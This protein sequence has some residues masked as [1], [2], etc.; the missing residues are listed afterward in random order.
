M[1]KAQNPADEKR[2][3]GAI[4][5][6]LRFF[7]PFVLLLFFAMLLLSLG[8]SAAR[9]KEQAIPDAPAES[10]PPP[11]ENRDDRFGEAI[12]VGSGASSEEGGE[13]P[14]EPSP[15]PVTLTLEKSDGSTAVLSMEDYLTGVLLAE[16]SPSFE[17]EAL[18]AQA[19]AARTYCLYRMER[20]SGKAS[21]ESGADVCGDYRHCMAY[22]DPAGAK[23]EEA[24]VMR[25]AAEATAGLCVEYTPTGALIDAVF[26]DSSHLSTESALAVWNADVPYLR[27]V[28]SGEDCPEKSYEFTA[29]EICRLVSGAEASPES[30]AFGGM[31]SDRSG[32]AETVYIAGNAF[33]AL[34]LR[35]ALTLPSTAFS[36]LYDSESG[37]YRFTVRGY[38]H[39]VGL[40]Q[41][42]AQQM[43]LEGASFEEILTHYY[44]DCRVAPH[45]FSP[46]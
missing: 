20:G 43:A 39:G 38:G 21:H 35:T 16:V 17:P 31:T 33:S 4:L 40:S 30:A 9:E 28:P 44:T 23:P 36:V 46:A 15:A 27:A 37:I 11:S 2:F 26:H 25:A 18:K 34:S 14:S 10:A 22:I 1:N 12:Y 3:P 42:G 24:A 41:K 7:T 6:G 45:R 32:R 19:V 29:E 8:A 13:L 5:P